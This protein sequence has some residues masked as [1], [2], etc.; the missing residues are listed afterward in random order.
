MLRAIREDVDEAR[1]GAVDARPV[2]DGGAGKTGG[3]RN[4]GDVDQLVES[5]PRD[6]KLGSDEA[7][8][9]LI[10]RALPGVELIY[11]QVPP[12]GLPRVSDALYFRL[13]TLSDAWEA[14]QRDRQAAF[15]L[16]DT[17]DNLMIELVVVRA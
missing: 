11:L 14:L 8:S 6:G 1:D 7:I 15:F 5:L 2:V 13:E 16:P 3:M 9:R 17:P 12:Q 10:N 4:G